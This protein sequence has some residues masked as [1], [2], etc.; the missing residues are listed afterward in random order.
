MS[1]HSD[2]NL[3]E[4]RLGWYGASVKRKNIDGREEDLVK[5]I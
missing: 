3:R 2:E 1:N 5:D 4:S